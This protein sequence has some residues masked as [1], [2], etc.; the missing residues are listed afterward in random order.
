[1]FIIFDFSNPKSA[2]S[3]M[4]ILLSFSKTIESTNNL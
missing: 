1:M 4:E 3:N 2:G